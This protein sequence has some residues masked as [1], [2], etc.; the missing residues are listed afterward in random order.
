VP[1]PEVRQ[2]DGRRLLLD[3]AL[4]DG[5]ALIGLGVDPRNSLSSERCEWLESQGVRY[6][7]LYPYAG[8]PQGHLTTERSTPAG[9][10]ELEDIHGDMIKW[11]RKAGH[12][13]GSIAVV[14][15]D[16][17]AFAVVAGDQLDDA[18]EALGRQVG[19]ASIAVAQAA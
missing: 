11:F 6:V 12:S 4:G 18:I 19:R 1:Q 5:F 9:L 7:A 15:P 3:D 16:K 8:R 14:R 10:V 17:F 13:S 2:I